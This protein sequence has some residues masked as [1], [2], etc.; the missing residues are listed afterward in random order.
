MT[1]GILKIRW[2]VLCEEMSGKVFLKTVS[3]QFAD[4]EFASLS[5]VRVVRIATHPDF[6]GMGYGTRAIQLLVDYYSGRVCSASD[7]FCEQVE[8]PAVNAESAAGLLYE[9]IAPRVRLPP[10][11]VEL[12]ERKAESL[13]YIGVSF[14]LTSDLLRY[15][16]K[17][18]M[19]MSM[20]S[21]FR[22]W[23]GRNSFVPVYLRQTAV[24]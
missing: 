8:V 5:G 21:F 10:L 6:Q 11:L 24:S 20:Y 18:C 7:K 12:S 4:H 9:V 15:G 19:L 14:G 17:W 3:I 1:S 16:N 13:D 23:S 22:F 2:L